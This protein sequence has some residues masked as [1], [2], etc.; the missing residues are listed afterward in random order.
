[1]KTVHPDEYRHLAASCCALSSNG[2]VVSC[3]VLQYIVELFSR[4][5]PALVHRMIMSLIL[6]SPYL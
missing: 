5:V 3:F 1:M 4:I 2:L 6:L